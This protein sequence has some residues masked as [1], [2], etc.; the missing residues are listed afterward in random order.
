MQRAA[1]QLV[2][3]I[4][5]RRYRCGLPIR[6]L[7]MRSDPHASKTKAT[8]AAVFTS[9]GSLDQNM[10]AQQKRLTTVGRP[11]SRARNGGRRGDWTMVPCSISSERRNSNLS[12]LLGIAILLRGSALSTSNHPGRSERLFSSDS[13]MR[14]SGHPMRCRTR[15]SL[16][17]RKIV[18]CFALS[19]P[20]CAPRTYTATTTPTTMATAVTIS[21]VSAV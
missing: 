1:T 12:T 2:P 10:S 21:A 11:K 18:F 20:S 6:N 17:S 5:H 8:Q 7:P 14:T 19:I 16:V 3:S 4:A 15:S 9:H 13:L